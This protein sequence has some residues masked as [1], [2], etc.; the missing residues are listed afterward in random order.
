MSALS[1]E[2][3]GR[4]LVAWYRSH[5]R[6]LPWRRTRDPYAIWISEVMLQQTRV[7][8]V[9]PYYERFLARFPTVSSLAYADPEDINA[10][11]SGLGYYRRARLMHGAAHSIVRDHGARLPADLDQLRALPG[12]GP[13]TAGAVAS[14]AFGIPATAV[15]G[16]VARVLA[17]VLAVEGDITRGEARRRI[18]RA[19][20]S[21]VLRS[22][23][24]GDL[25]QALIELGALVC[26]VGIPECSRCPIA[27][28]CAARA[29]RRQ[30]EIPAPKKRPRRASIDVTGVVAIDREGRVALEK[31]P[32]AGLFAGM[33]C[34]PTLEGHLEVDQ[35][36]DEL[37]RRYGWTLDDVDLIGD[38]KHVLT[39]R[40]IL[41]KVAI[42]RDQ[43]GDAC[44]PDGMR[45]VAIDELRSLGVPSVTKRALRLALSSDESLMG[46]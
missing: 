16:N 11:W 6:D 42:A 46:R 41:M 21:I 25:T 7:D 33:W 39:H 38:L 13:Y 31:Q 4:G 27:R 26:S 14:I 15:D 43:D 3:I 20:E 45:R 10:A 2:R 40:D 8:T 12:F 30:A 18:A 1:A 28:E 32:D 35:V 9:I 24:P 34:L 29:L 36:V 23:A 19:A 37:E 44:L 17:R 5:R 22:N